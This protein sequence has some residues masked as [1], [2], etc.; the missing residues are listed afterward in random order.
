MKI[1]I[2]VLVLAFIVIAGIVLFYQT[3]KKAILT[4]STFEQCAEN[5]FLILESYP[6][7]CTTSDG[8]TF[9]QIIKNNPADTAAQSS[10]KLISVA[11]P[12]PRS[13]IQSPLTATGTAR[14]YWFFEASFPIELFDENNQLIAQ[15]I[16]QAQG[17]WMT[18]DFVPFTATLTYTNSVEQNGT[19]VFKKDNPSGLS[20]NDDELRIP[21][22]IGAQ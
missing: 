16:G 6:A 1:K 5:G 13:L 14:G 18:E 19:L 3:E 12:T 11:I 22:V 17:D 8:R 21:V 10:H 7:R 2:I 9:T 15:G 4:I 20:E